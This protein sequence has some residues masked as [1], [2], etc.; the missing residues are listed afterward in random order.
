LSA[1]LPPPPS[2]D[3]LPRL[4]LAAHS[5]TLRPRLIEEEPLDSLPESLHSSRLPSLPVGQRVRIESVNVD[6][7]IPLPL[8]ARPALDQA[9]L[10][11]PTAEVSA[12]AARSALIPA[13]TT[14]APFL[15]LSLPDPYERRRPVGIPT[16]EPEPEA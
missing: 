5:T 15:K 8:L 11:D 12:D 6:E 13:R 9:S 14:P 10:D 1:C 4:P 2:L 16:V 3:I 7:P